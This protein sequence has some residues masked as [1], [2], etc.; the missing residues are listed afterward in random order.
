[1]LLAQSTPEAKALLEQTRTIPIVSPMLSDPI[2]S[3]FTE[4]RE[5]PG[6]TI[7]GFTTSR[8]VWRVS[9][10]G[11][12]TEIRPDLNTIAT[13]LHPDDEAPSSEVQR[14]LTAAASLHHVEL[15]LVRDVDLE[16]AVGVFAA[17][18]A[19]SESKRGLDRPSRDLYSGAP[20]PDPFFSGEI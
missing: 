16:R 10:L 17:D 14:A 18:A 11:L 15:T 3:G 9:W 12:L 5:N 20:V 1:M 4:L 19:A 7:T 8:K 13:I 6:G 2:G